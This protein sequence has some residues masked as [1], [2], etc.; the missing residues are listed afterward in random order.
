ML[1]N[2]L[3]FKRWEHYQIIV[4][5]DIFTANPTEILALLTGLYDT[6]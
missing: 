2:G 1:L 4:T 5:S 6:L 3:L